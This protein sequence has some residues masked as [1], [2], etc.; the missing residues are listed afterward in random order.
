[1]RQRAPGAQSLGPA[2]LDGWQ[3]VI[4]RD[5]YASV[6]RQPG[7]VVH[8]ILW[9]LTPRDLAGLHA[10]ERLD[11]GLYRAQTLAVRQGARLRR[12]R[13]YISR[14]AAAGRPVPGYQEDIIAAARDWDFPSQY[15]TELARW[16]PAA[17]RGAA[18]VTGAAG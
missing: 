15:I 10:Y 17:G 14:S 3:F 12:A 13:V 9:R 2:R 11:T 18:P 6:V 8:G 7:S 1:M 4:T 16:L 5:R